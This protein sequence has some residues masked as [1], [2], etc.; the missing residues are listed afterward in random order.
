MLDE[1]ELDDRPHPASDDH[2]RQLSRSS[3]HPGV[4][5]SAAAELP[6]ESESSG[7]R[8]TTEVYK[9]GGGGEDLG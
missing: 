4:L 9:R 7:A 1:F 5:R 6:K 8:G 3:A 2:I